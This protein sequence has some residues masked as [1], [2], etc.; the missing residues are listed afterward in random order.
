MAKLKT[1]ETTASAADFLNEIAD[2]KIRADC[3]KIAGLM[4]AATGA[5]R[6]MWGVAIVI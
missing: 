5:K 6:K 3:Q 1:T 2:E 4:A